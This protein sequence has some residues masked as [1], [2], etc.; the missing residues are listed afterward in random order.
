MRFAAAYHTELA[1]LL[2][3]LWAAVSLAA[4][5]ILGCLPIDVSQI[6][7]VGEMF[8]RFQEGED[9]C[10]RLET[11]GSRVHDLILGPVDDRVHLVICLEEAAG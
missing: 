4:E 1:M 5:F 6:C 8:A 2:S 10:S 3:V 9:W 11:F 7:V